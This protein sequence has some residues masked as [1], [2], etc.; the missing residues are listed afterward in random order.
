MRL[1]PLVGGFVLLLGS[2]CSPVEPSSIKPSA[3]A[4]PTATPAPSPEAVA[5]SFFQD[6]EQS[7]YA[8]M[9]DLLSDT[10]KAATPQEL[11]LRRYTSIR[12]GIGETKLRVQPGDPELVG[13]AAARVPFQVTHS[14]IMYGDIVESNVLPL[15]QEQGMWKVT[16]EP[17][18]IFQ[19]LTATRRVRARAEVPPR[20]RILDRNGVPLADNG[21][22]VAVGVVPGQITDEP[23]L[24]KVL[25]DALSLP[26]Q[27]IKQRYQNGQPD[28][29]MPILERPADDRPDLQTEIGSLPGVSLQDR[30]ARVYP[31]GE[32]AAHLVG[33]VAHPTADELRQ[34]ASAGYDESDWI[35]RAGIEAW[36]EQR[37]A[38]QH[39][40]KIEI[41]DADERVVRTIAE[42]K[43][44]PGEDVHLALDAGFQKA[45]ANV[46]GDKAGSVVV[47][48]PANNSVLGLASRPSFDPNHFVTG[49]S[50]AEWQELNGPTRPLVLRATESAYPTG[51]TFKVVTMAAGMEKAGVK[52]TD[53]FDCGM[54]WHGLP[55]VTLHNWQ[56][57]GTLNLIDALAESCNP[58]FFDIGLKLDAMDP[59]ALP[60]V[61]RGFGFGQ[62]TRISGVHEV[63]GTIPD[64][65]WKQQQT[66]EPWTSG[67]TVNLAIGQGYLLATPLQVAN[68][69]AALANGGNLLSPTLV[70]DEQPPSLGTLPVSSATRGAILDG[71]RRVTS[72]PAGTAYYA[73]RDEKTAV[74][75][76]T[77]SAE[78]ENPDAH[79]WFVGF[80][81]ADKPRLLVLIMV[82][83]GQ[84]GGTVAAPLA[85]ELFD[86]L[87]PSS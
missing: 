50:D 37:L 87:L 33:Y 29:F 84:H 66:G 81:P 36:A 42:K 20:G 3:P 12:D 26:A 19:D 40:G 10:A 38:G 23:A 64:P 52:T 14:L 65:L 17:S 11:F 70:R 44:A 86:Q 68:A 53:T 60:N 13:D 5:A 2:S 27:T 4:I 75:A 1:V 69:Y 9:Y 43:S 21:T 82:E 54:D 58:A 73:F 34:L 35:G 41:V 80:A 18:L 22:I 7:A 85:R 77:G 39:G 24:L 49:V 63:T 15:V 56:A 8:R 59:S 61:A 76:K 25:S 78:N 46:L 30:K 79:A 67:D 28:W 72:T 16:W 71:M 55:G 83:G 47:L 74:A 48:D 51:S 32:S 31:L 6:W 62:P 45:A 57:Q